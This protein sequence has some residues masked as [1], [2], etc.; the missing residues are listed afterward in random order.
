MRVAFVNVSSIYLFLYTLSLSVCKML[1]FY[2]LLIPIQISLNKK[3]TSSHC[4]HYKQN[5]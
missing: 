3:F 2:Y 5:K 4:N 1:D